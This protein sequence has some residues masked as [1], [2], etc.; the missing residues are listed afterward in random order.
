[1]T[2]ICTFDEIGPGDVDKVGGKGLGLALLTRAG[3]PVPAGFCVTTGASRRLAGRAP[4]AELA[5]VLAAAYRE[6]GGG[7]VAV[8]SSAVAED[9]A[10]TSFAGQQETVLGVVGDSAVLVALN[11]CWASPKTDRAVAYRQ[12][13]GMDDSA[14]AMAVVVQRLVPAEVAGV[15][16][17]RDPLD[18]EERT[19]LVEA[20][21][22]LGEG[23]VSGRV[24]PDRYRL[25]YDTGAVREQHVSTKTKMVRWSTQHSPGGTEYV[26]VPAAQQAVPCL[27][28]V[29]LAQLADLGRRVEAY[30]GAPRDV[31]WAWADGRFW[32]LQARPITTV[33]AA[34][35]DAVRREEMAALAAKAEPGGTV[36]TRTNLA[37]VLAAPTPMTWAIVR[38]F[39]SGRGGYGLMYRDLGFDLDPALDEEGIFDLICGRPYCNL[40][41]QLRL[42]FRQPPLE[43]PFKAFRAAPA[44][45]LDPRPV[46]NPARA[47]LRF[48]LLLP[49]LTLRLMVR[50]ARLHRTLADWLRRELFPTFA[51]ECER[52]MARDLA[53]LDTPALLECLE[54][55]IRRTLYD[56][57]RDSLKPT[58]LAALVLEDLERKVVPLV[59]PEHAREALGQIVMGVHPEPEADLPAAIRDLTAGLLDQ[60]EFLR[61]FGHRG[62]QE[63]ELAQPRWAEAPPSWSGQAQATQSAGARASPLDETHRAALRPDIERLHTYLALRETGKHYLMMGYAVLR[64]ILVELDRRYCLGGGVFYLTPEELPRLAAGHDFTATIAQRR[65]RRLAALSLVVPQVLFSDDLDAIGRPVD[66]AGADTL[67][68]TP[69]SAGAAEGLALVLDEPVTNFVSAEPFILVCPSTDPAWVPLFVRACG[70][71]METGGVLSHGAIVAREFGLPAVAGLPDVT[72]QF[73]TGQRLRVDGTTGRVTLVGETLRG[74]E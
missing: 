30:F 14:L 40:S 39:M 18:P 59:G 45:A 13:Q 10:V 9:G 6:L 61:R 71:V 25:D 11:R 70:L 8:R 53:G 22:G 67:Q 54:H 51:A 12:H 32:L 1:M 44:L 28:D 64:R 4:D 69:L 37:E 19:M 33:T 41:R 62:H 23:V 60:A 34:E 74:S 42:Q 17:T 26:A 47:G 29:Q 65:R 50:L 5:A 35:R 55:W 68:G 24:T 3:L 48:W 36:W 72:R 2:D 58:A 7:P 56:F 46:P 38:R 73:R 63:M 66:V 31:E 52:E 49:F 21:W 43:Y 27:S 57:A 20:A 15:L 16:F